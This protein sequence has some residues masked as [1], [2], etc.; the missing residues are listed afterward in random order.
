MKQILCYGDSNTW[1]YDPT[2]QG[3]H[4]WGVRWTSRV[5]EALGAQNVRILEEGLCGRTTAF[6]DPD[7]EWRSGLRTLPLVLETHRPIDGAVLMLGTNDCKAC[8]R[9]DE[10]EIAEGLGRCIDVLLGDVPAD[11]LL[12]V[13]PPLLGEDVWLPQCDPQFDRASVGL[14][15]RLLPAYR[16]IAR[17]K[18]VRLI[19]ASDFAKAEAFDCEHLT[20]E[21]HAALAEAILAALREWV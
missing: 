7:R 1:G 20:A 4:A 15:R 11:R 13:S 21:G 8:Y 14:S 12:V 16:E 19:A 2:T 18:G 6:D 3:R 17:Q 5:Q 9:A 10:R